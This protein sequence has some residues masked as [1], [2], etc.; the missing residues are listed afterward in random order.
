M[1]GTLVLSVCSARANLVCDAIVELTLNG[2]FASDIGLEFEWH[3]TL[4]S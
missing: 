2:K 3:I 1:S 4:G